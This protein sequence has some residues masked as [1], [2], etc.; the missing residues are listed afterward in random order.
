MANT[1]LEG[2]YYKK[3]IVDTA[4]GAS[5]YFTAEVP[6][7]VAVG[8][9]KRITFTVSEGAGDVTLQYKGSGESTWVDE[10][11]SP[12]TAV[13]AK[14]IDAWTHGRKWRAICKQ[15]AYASGDLTFGFEW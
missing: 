11:G 1:V 8:G 12:Y 4:P 7:S 14:V 2:K 6:E 5:G 9:D 13:T 15:T 3:V 10:D